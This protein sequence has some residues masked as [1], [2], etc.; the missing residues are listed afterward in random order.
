MKD[1]GRKTYQF[2]HNECIFCQYV[3]T[4]LCWYGPKGEKEVIPKDEGYGIMISAF[5]SQEFGFGMYL[6]EDELKRVNKFGREQ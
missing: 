4:S 1:A 3:F 2:G 6:S 5:Q